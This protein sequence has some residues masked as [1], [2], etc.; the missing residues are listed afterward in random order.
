[1]G[2]FVSGSITF[3]DDENHEISFALGLGKRIDI[4][5]G[6]A[7]RNHPLEEIRRR[8]NDVDALF[9]P[10]LAIRKIRARITTPE[11]SG[12]SDG[13]VTYSAVFFFDFGSTVSVSPRVHNARGLTKA[14]LVKILLKELNIAPSDMYVGFPRGTDICTHMQTGSAFYTLNQLSQEWGAFFRI[15]YCGTGTNRPVAIFCDPAADSMITPFTQMITGG[16]GKYALF[17]YKHGLANVKR[18]NMTYAPSENGSGDNVRVGLGPDG[19]VNFYRTVA[20]TEGVEV[21][22]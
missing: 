18:F 21:Y 5:W 6:Y 11:V 10:G 12:D 19:K 22:K 8:T 13:K 1:M 9:S 2:R 15:D 20:T 16:R 4:L 17:E 3:N 14:G 7:D